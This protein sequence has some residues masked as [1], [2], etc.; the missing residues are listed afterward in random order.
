M[1][2]MMLGGNYFIL[3]FF[4]YF[5]YLFLEMREG[6]RKGEKHQCKRDRL[7]GCLSHAPDRA[8]GLQPRRVP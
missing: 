6:E 1:M 3:V 7:I 8:S 2:K 4:Q 5:I